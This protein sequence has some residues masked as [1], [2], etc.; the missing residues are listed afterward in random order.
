MKEKAKRMRL[1]ARITEYERM[2]T[3]HDTPQR[4]KDMQHR[5]GSMKK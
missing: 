5:P 1:E 3:D 2:M 4:I